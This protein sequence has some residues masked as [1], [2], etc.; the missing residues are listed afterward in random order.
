MMKT[1]VFPPK[2]CDCNNKEIK[3]QEVKTDEDKEVKNRDFSKKIET[4]QHVSWY[5]T[6]LYEGNKWQIIK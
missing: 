6:V 5:N 1:K 2:S 3:A 4:G